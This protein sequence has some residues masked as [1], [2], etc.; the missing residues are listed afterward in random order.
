MKLTLHIDKEH[1]EEVIVY[2]HSKTK[3]VEALVNLINEEKLNTTPIIGYSGE[4]IIEVR[5]GEVHC[6]FIEDKKLYASMDKRDVLIKCRLY[7]IEN[8]LGNDFIKIN[9]STVANV[10]F[11]E[12]F[13]VSIGAAL[14]VH[15]KNGRRDYVSRRQLKSV[16][17]RFG[18]K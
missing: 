5:P 12:R 15:F 7:E 17:E 14:T 6:F 18:I 10:K 2:A 16:K 11:V 3:L 9:Q 4:D 13:S 1:E 8:A